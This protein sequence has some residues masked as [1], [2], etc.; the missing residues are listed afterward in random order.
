MDF[1]LHFNP[2]SSSVCLIFFILT[3][4]PLNVANTKRCLKKLHPS[5]S[6][7]PRHSVICKKPVQFK[8]HKT[9]F[10]FI[11]KKVQKHYHNRE[12]KYKSRTKVYLDDI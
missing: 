7:T 11:T 10:N 6:K 12:K 2:G 1:K 9:V 8:F 3:D 4:L 5:Y